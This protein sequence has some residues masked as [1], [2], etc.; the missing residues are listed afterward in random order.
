MIAI[1]WRDTHNGISNRIQLV[2]NSAGIL[3]VFHG[4][5]RLT[6]VKTFHINTH[7]YHTPPSHVTWQYCWFY[8][9]HRKIRSRHSARVRSAKYPAS[10]QIWDSSGN[11]GGGIDEEL[12][13]SSLIC[14]TMPA[15]ELTTSTHLQQPWGIDWLSYH[16]MSHSTLNMSFFSWRS[17]DETKPNTK[18][19]T[20]QEQNSLS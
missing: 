7:E 9:G 16:L 6:Q 4:D 15:A 12:S 19:Q 20:M 13:V 17:T 10:N 8:H 3:E 14:E 5:H 18:N 1:C 11:T 2:K